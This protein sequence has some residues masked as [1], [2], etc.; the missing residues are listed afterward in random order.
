MPTPQRV[1]MP[2]A[3]PPILA[4]RLLGGVYVTMGT[5]ELGAIKHVLLQTVTV[6]F[7]VDMVCAWVITSQSH[8]VT[9]CPRIMV[10]IAVRNVEMKSAAV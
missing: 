10:P 9:A 4:P 1:A 8:G 5:V 3:A 7:V 6:R 2:S